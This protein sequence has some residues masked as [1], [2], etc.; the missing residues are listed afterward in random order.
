MLNVLIFDPPAADPGFLAALQMQAALSL[1]S[2]IVLNAWH[3]TMVKGG[4]PQGRLSPVQ[5]KS[6][7]APYGSE[8]LHMHA[9]SLSQTRD[10]GSQYCVAQAEAHLALEAYTVKTSLLGSNGTDTS[11]DLKEILKMMCCQLFHLGCIVRE[12]W[13]FILPKWSKEAESIHLHSP[14]VV[15]NCHRGRNSQC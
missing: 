12:S 1:G 9:S 13:N 5:R 14:Q 3:V 15:S 11:S 8:A 10:Q 4:E 6:G 2:F 7:F